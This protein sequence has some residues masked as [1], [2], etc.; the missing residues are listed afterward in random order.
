MVEGLLHGKVAIV[1]GGSGALGTGIAR[2]LAAAGAAVVLA[3]VKVDAAQAVAAQIEAAGGRALAVGCDV[4]ARAQV[5]AMVSQAIE[6][7]GGVDILVN[8]AAIYPLRPW[9][10]I[11]EEEWDRVFA[12]NVKG[13]YLCARAVYPSMQARGGGKIV[14][15]S[16]ITFFLGK[17]DKL[18]DYVSSK[19]AIVG[20][21]KALARELGPDNIHV[22]CIAP[23]AFPTNA[24]K[25]H[26]DPAG[27][28]AF[29]LENQAIQR[30]GTP[31]DMANAVLFF[32]SSLSDFVTGQSL[33]VDGGW[34][35]R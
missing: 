23:G 28:N 5:E 18:L 34:A 33:L 10:E 7:F 35:M 1:T 29:V 11:S 25:I 21:T 8:N 9:T 15:I 6:I 4:A 14:N 16:S 19:G 20:F 30:R 17:W 3:D 26:P 27:Y 24:E 12:V 32:A 13:Y 31:Q 2:G 22:N